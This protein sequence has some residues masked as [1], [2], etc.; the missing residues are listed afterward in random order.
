MVLTLSGGWFHCSSCGSF[1]SCFLILGPTDLW[2][3]RPLLFCTSF[4]RHL[5]SFVKGDLF[6]YLSHIL[7]NI[8]PKHPSLPFLGLDFKLLKHRRYKLIPFIKV[9]SVFFPLLNMLLTKEKEESVVEENSKK[10]THN[11]PIDI[12]KWLPLHT[13]FAYLVSN[14]I[15]PTTH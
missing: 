10:Y 6:C 14:W 15:V 11:I 2:V 13:Y 3:R 12:S 1:S 9:L 8:L 4:Q 5:S 7:P